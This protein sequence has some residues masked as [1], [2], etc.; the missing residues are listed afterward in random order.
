M[1]NWI[2]DKIVNYSEIIPGYAFKSK[3]FIEKGIPVIKIGN[4]KSE[5]VDIVNEETQY[6][7][8]TFLSSIN[9]KY[10]IIRGDI[11]I[12]L[13]GSHL[14]QPNSV[15]GRVGRYRDDSVALVNQRAAKIVSKKNKSD[16]DFLYHLLST[17]T[18]RKEIA[19]LAHGAANQ[20]NVSHKDIEKIKVFWPPFPI[21]K[22]IAAVLSAYDDLIENN[23][24]RVAILEKMAEEL[25]REW[26]VRLRFP[27][28]EKVK[29]VKGVPEGWEVKKLPKIADIT[30]GKAFDGSRFNTSA[31]GKPIIRIRNIPSSTTND[32]TDEYAVDKY[33]IKKGDLLVGMDG[34]FHINH[35]YSE[36]AYLVQ[37]SCRISAKETRLK[38]YLAKA[39]YAPVKYY[40]AILQG[41]TVGHLGAKHLNAIDILIPPKNID[42]DIFNKLL[43]QKVK[44]VTKCNLLKRTRDQLLSRLM[45]GKID[46][47]N[48]DIQFPDS[49]KE[50][51]SNE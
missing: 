17:Y 39:V 35:W 18:L 29:I 19:L 5:M 3:D 44:H 50:D 27:G 12:S 45:S 1:K 38:G 32:Y 42:L 13:T 40:E 43:D 49:M 46:L 16:K 14:T 6:V 48:I 24:R 34:E 23:K 10:Q 51:I 33:I 20:A 30:Y 7:E 8:N 37:R 31:Y 26:F 9:T 4:V 11:L 28:H 22:K 2:K 21:Q 15:V 47:E 41:A 25:Y 36:D